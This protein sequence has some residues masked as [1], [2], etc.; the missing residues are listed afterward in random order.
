MAAVC[1]QKPEVENL[2]RGVR[3]VVEKWYGN[4]FG[5]SV[6]NVRRDETGYRK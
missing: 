6:N 3:C 1:F 2:S 4:S 5:P